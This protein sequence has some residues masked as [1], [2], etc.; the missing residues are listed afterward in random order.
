M[1]NTKQKKLVYEIVT[2]SKSHLTAYEIYNQAKKAIPSISLGTVYRNLKD[3]CAARQIKRITTKE[4][5]D[6]F[7][8]LNYDHQHFICSNCGVI[9]D[10]F[11]SKC[12][13][14]KEELKYFQIEHIDITFSGL[15]NDC[16]EGGKKNGIK[17]KQNRS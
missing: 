3:L 5:T 6:H 9:I 11:N 15:C 13:Y 1:R 17:G 8:S 10:V 16:L 2:S 4:G 14:E 12:I 7:D